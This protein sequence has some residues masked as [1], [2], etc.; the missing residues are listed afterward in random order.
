M[1]AIFEFPLVLRNPLIQKNWP[2]SP[3]AH[4]LRRYR[5]DW[6]TR[7]RLDLPHQ[8]RAGAPIVGR[9]YARLRLAGISPGGAGTTSRRLGAGF[10]RACASLKDSRHE[11]PQDYQER[12]CRRR[13]LRK[14]VRTLRQRQAVWTGYYY[15]GRDEAREDR[16]GDF[17]RHRPQ[18]G[19]A[20]VGR[21][22]MPA[23]A[24]RDRPHARRLRSLRTRD[25]SQSK[26]PQDAGSENHL[27]LARLRGQCSIPPQS[28]PSPRSTS[29]STAMRSMTQARTLKDG[30]VI[31]ARRA[32]VA[33]NRELAL[34]SHDLQ[35]GAR[36][37]L[38]RPRRTPAAGVRKEQGERRA[39]YYADDAVWQ[40]VRDC[41]GHRTA[42]T[43][44]DLAYLFP[45]SAPAT[46]CAS[47]CA[48]SSTTR[49][50]TVQQGKTEQA[51][52]AFMLTD[53]ETR[54]Q[55]RTWAPYVDRIRA[56][57]PCAVCLAAGHAGRPPAHR[58]HAAPALR[59]RR[60]RPP[61]RSGRKR[62]AIADLAARLQ[63]SSSSAMLEPQGGPVRWSF[64]PRPRAAR[65]HRSSRSPKTVYRRVGE[66]GQA[67]E[68]MV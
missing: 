26:A 42:A 58:G 61:A 35:Q 1:T 55:D 19:Q 67:H 30:T 53:P 62:P 65:A 13:M 22:R 56:R 50:W 59:R 49:W 54:R 11:P 4:A 14:R 34:F 29:P 33:A 45:A 40:A 41:A 36:V 37:G 2:K 39:R 47:P 60:A 24:G 15:N 57:S 38:H 46:C 12:T 17:A 52:G 20:Q 10:L 25:H 32:T 27:E 43:R 7:Q 21:T 9:M 8:P 63:Y 44:I 5:L 51:L 6:L 23:G 64:G 66:T 18:R 31:P 28:T 3:A 48:T 68:V 16:T